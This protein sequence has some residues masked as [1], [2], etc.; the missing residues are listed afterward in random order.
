MIVLEN[1]I[2]GTEFRVQ[3]SPVSTMNET[4]DKV[5]FSRKQK[6]GFPSYL[7]K[8]FREKPF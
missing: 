8:K 6:R 2:M 3:S 1:E 4:V 5:I 7:G